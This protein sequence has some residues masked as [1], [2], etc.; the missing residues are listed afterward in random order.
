[1]STHNILFSI[2]QYHLNYSK[3]ATMEFFLGTLKRVRNS[4]GERA[5]RVRATEV[6]QYYLILIGVSDSL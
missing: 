4:R 5:I 3:S 6:L 1:M 2:Y